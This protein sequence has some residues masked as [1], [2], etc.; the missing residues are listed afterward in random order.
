MFSVFF[1]YLKPLNEAKIVNLTEQDKLSTLFNQLRIAYNQGV[2]GLEECT[3]LF[4]LNPEQD[5]EMFE[6]IHSNYEL[7]RVVRWTN[8]NILVKLGKISYKTLGVHLRII[9]SMLTKLKEHGDL[10]ED[11]Y[12]TLHSNLTKNVLDLHYK[13][14]TEDLPF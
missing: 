13:I 9:C 10:R 14:N 6:Y 4:V 8:R 1:D 5:E 7:M 2:K 12:Y 3:R 11:V